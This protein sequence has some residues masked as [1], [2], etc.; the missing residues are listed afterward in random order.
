MAYRV[1][2]DGKLTPVR[3]ITMPTLL[4]I[5]PRGHFTM[6]RCSAI[7]ALDKLALKLGLYNN[8][9]IANLCEFLANYPVV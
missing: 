1:E 3:I 8:H 9:L 5:D 6:L 4:R 2:G 7:V